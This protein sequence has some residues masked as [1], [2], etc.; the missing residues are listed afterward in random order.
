MKLPLYLLVLL[1]LAVPAFATYEMTLLAVQ[2]T[3]DGYMGSPATITL[4]IIPGTG[5]VLLE[6]KPLT[7]TDTQF[8][9]RFAKQYACAYTQKDCSNIDF[10]Y[11][12]SSSAPIVGGPSAGAAMSML[13]IAALEE[14]ELDNSVAIT[15]TI[16][17]GG[18]IGPV[19]SIKEKIDAAKMVDAQT[20]II[21]LGESTH[22]ENNTSTDLIAYGKSLGIDVHEAGIVEDIIDV[23]YGEPYQQPSTP[24]I[25]ANDEYER[26]MSLVAAKLCSRSA[27]LK[28]LVPIAQNVS[29]ADELIQIAS[30]EVKAGRTYSAASRCFSANIILSN[31]ANIY[32]EEEEA[33]DRYSSLAKK[34]DI[35]SNVV[36]DWEIDSMA[37][38]Q[39]KMIVNERISESQELLDQA[40]ET[41]SKNDSLYYYSFANER[42][43]SAVS[44]SEFANITGQEIDLSTNLDVSCRSKIEEASERIQYANSALPIEVDGLVDALNEAK[45][46]EAEDDFVQCLYQASLAK[47]RA[48]TLIGTIGVA[49]EEQL[50]TLVES[51]IN[52]AKR[53]IEKESQRGIF[54][55]AGYAYAEYADS[56]LEDSPGNAILFSQ[57]A[58]ELSNFDLYFSNELTEVNTSPKTKGSAGGY[59]FLFIYIMGILTGVVIAYIV[60]SRK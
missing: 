59:E 45:V 25:Q 54:P 55:I 36:D 11:T 18:I 30:D 27:R 28:E 3:D 32:L 22:V 43:Y 1:I 24:N 29:R 12:I 53:N 26:I 9:T 5:K 38:L 56:L 8:S 20:V 46:L 4:D 44:W 7:R 14:K 51:K 21:P 16:N 41:E 15:G 35:F 34:I 13:T 48:D 33:E 37:K 57:Y 40:Y 60:L 50:Q 17:S 10:I 19:G 52:V 42:L 31:A 2:E 23:F 39:T 47:A 58:L 6:T 49:T